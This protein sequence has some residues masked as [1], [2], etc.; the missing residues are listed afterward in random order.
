[1][2]TLKQLKQ[3]FVLFTMLVS[4]VL[5]ATGIT[6]LYHIT[7]INLENDSIR[8]MEAVAASPAQAGEDL[9]EKEENQDPGPMV[10]ELFRDADGNVTVVGGEGIEELSDEEYR[11]QLYSEAERGR[12]RTGVIADRSLRYLKSGGPGNGIVFSDMSAEEAMLGHLLQNSLVFAAA[13]IL[14]LLFLS[15]VLAR[16]AARP[17]EE[18]FRQQRQFI[19]DA[20]HELKTPLTV[21]LTDA[22]LLSG[23]DLPEEDRDRLEAD[24]FSM[25]RQMRGLVERML[26]L[27]RTENAGSTRMEP[28]DLSEAVKDA[29]L[30]FEPVCFEQGHPL[31]SRITPGIMVSG[32]RDQLTQLVQIFLDNA[33]K[34]ADLGGGITLSL[35]PVE[36]HAGARY[37]EIAV[38]NPC[39]DL[40]PDDAEKLFRRF[41]RSDRARA[42]DRSYGLGLSIAQAVT[43]NHGGQIRCEIADGT[44]TFRVRLR[45]R[46]R[47][48]ISVSFL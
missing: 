11:K 42:M 22:D 44:V 21:I 23:E 10:F 30:T 24:I 26:D 46:E 27:A 4:V 32:D 28:V 14:G 17:V 19:A 48:G 16:R 6:L 12:N 9:P 39:S 34:Y 41:Y 1:M 31:E 45:R 13:A 25:S 38:S 8:T 3:R 36:G 43:E 33:V 15:L 5:L 2:N 47:S 20:S 18:S 35:A 7:R 37:A 29:C 40:S